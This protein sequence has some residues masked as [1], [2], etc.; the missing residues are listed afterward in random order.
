MSDRL[1]S[2]ERQPPSQ[3]EL[4]RDPFGKLVLTLPN[5]QRVPGVVPVRSFPIQAPEQGIALVDADGH[6]VAWI[7]ELAATPQP[8]QALIR[9]ALR[10]R[11]FMPEIEAVVSVSSFSTPCAWRVRTD[12]GETEFVLRGEE[13]IRRLGGGNGLLITDSHGIQFY[14]RDLTRLDA[15]SRRLLDRFL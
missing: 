9:E 5:G 10:L 7:D 3:F 12:H 4:V 11:E 13:D 15:D 2:P 1:L 6:E 14:L 8:Q